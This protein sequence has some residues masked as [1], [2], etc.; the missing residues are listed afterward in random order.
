M[1]DLSRPHDNRQQLFTEF[2]P[3]VFISLDYLF[4]I[5]EGKFKELEDK[6]DSAADS[7]VRSI[8]HQ[9]S[10]SA[11]SWSLPCYS[12]YLARRE[13]FASVKDTWKIPR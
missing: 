13:D 10:G 11:S 2:L 7:C 6:A 5:K 3:T 1:L 4:H 9:T 8:D 12:T